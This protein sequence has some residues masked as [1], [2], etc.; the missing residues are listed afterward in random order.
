M[1]PEGAR[2]VTEQF[3]RAAAASLPRDAQREAESAQKAI[4]STT[5]R[6]CLF[7]AVRFI[8]TLNGHVPGE[9]R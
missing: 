9:V 1:T 6:S 4:D 8:F 5:I 2:A 7:K 3:M